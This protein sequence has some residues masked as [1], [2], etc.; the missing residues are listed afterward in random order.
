M[1]NEGLQAQ[2][3]ADPV[4][5]LRL[6]AELSPRLPDDAIVTADSGSS[7]NWYA[8][9]LRFRGNIRGSPVAVA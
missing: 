6:F 5:P 1:G 4:N 3:D 8:R 2:V 7:A 9:Q